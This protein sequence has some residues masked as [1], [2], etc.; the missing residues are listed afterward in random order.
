MPSRRSSV[1]L[2]NET[3]DGDYQTFRGEDGGYIREHF[4]GKYPE[5]KELVADLT[6]EQIFNLRLGGHDDK[7]LYAAYK[8]AM[9]TKGKP[10]VILAQSIKGAELGPTSRHVTPPTRSRSSPWKH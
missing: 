5:T 8:E 6:D 9:E 10:T 1:Q 7:K 4:F 2:M 3:L